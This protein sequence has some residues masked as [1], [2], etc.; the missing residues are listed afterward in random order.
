MSTAIRMYVSLLFWIVV[1]DWDVCFISVGSEM[2]GEIRIWCQRFCPQAKD[3][4]LKVGCVMFHTPL[5]CCQNIYVCTMLQWIY[6]LTQYNNSNRKH[7]LPPP[8]HTGRLV[9]KARERQQVVDRSSESVSSHI[10]SLQSQL[11]R[12]F[13]EQMSKASVTERDNLRQW[14][15]VILLNTHPRYIHYTHF[16]YSNN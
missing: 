15:R 14:R 2:A 1:T 8:T 12:R 3:N 9:E 16:K 5:S 13:L 4:L 10:F 11:R 7:A 6:S